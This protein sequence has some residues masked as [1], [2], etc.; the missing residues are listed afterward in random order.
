LERAGVSG[1]IL[2][3]NDSSPLA[4]HDLG[5]QIDQESFDI[6]TDKN[7]SF[8]IKPEVSTRLTWLGGPILLP[9][10]TASVRIAAR[11][12]EPILVKLKDPRFPH[13]TQEHADYRLMRLE[14]YKFFRL[15]SVVAQ[16]K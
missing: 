10:S 15:G 1:R 14:N 2:D 6:K 5:V 7:G 11:G 3:A 8:S 9:A 4:F 16:R 12:Y 13:D